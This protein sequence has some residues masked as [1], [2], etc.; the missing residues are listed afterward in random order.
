MAKRKCDQCGN[1]FNT[2]SP[3][4]WVYRFRSYGRESRGRLLYFCSFSCQERYKR[5]HPEKKEYK[6]GFKN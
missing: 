3:S 5:E 2:P 4:E 1:T 6:T